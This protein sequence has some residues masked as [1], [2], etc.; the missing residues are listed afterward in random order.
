VE[1][2]QR[3][4]PDDPFN[5]ASFLVSLPTGNLGRLFAPS[6]ASP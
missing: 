2:A 5:Q 6:W 4:P 1:V 3:P